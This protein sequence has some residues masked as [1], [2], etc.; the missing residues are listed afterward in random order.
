MSAARPID[1]T[2]ARPW[3][4]AE[5]A[6]ARALMP[7]ALHLGE[8]A[9]ALERTV[10]EL[11]TE[12]KLGSDRDRERLRVVVEDVPMQP[13]WRALAAVAAIAAGH[14]C[15]RQA[16]LDGHLGRG[17]PPELTA[18]RREAVRA[19]MAQQQDGAGMSRASVARLF[20]VSPDLI[21]RAEAGEVEGGR[22]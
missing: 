14:G 4:D 6:Q 19:V 3:T 18:A 9:E 21:A 15:S 12:F 13:R 7:G 2:W 20:G 8:V 17:F 1:M 11:V 22:P 5:R 10:L 16:L